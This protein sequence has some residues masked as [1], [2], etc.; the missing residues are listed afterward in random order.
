MQ[1]QKQ[2]AID[3]ARIRYLEEASLVQELEDMLQEVQH[4][5]L[6]DT[7]ACDAA[8]SQ[9]D[10]KLQQAGLPCPADAALS[11]AKHMQAAYAA[12]RLQLPAVPQQQPLHGNKSSSVAGNVSP[13]DVDDDPDQLGSMHHLLGVTPQ[14]L[15]TLYMPNKKAAQKAHAPVMPLLEQRVEQQAQEAV[16]AVAGAAAGPDAAAH[17]LSSIGEKQGQLS[18][19]R[20]ACSEK[21]LSYTQCAQGHLAEVAAMQQRLVQLGQCILSEQPA[22]DQKHREYLEAHMT[23]LLGKLATMQ[24]QMRDGTYDARTVPALQAIKQQL[25]RT[26]QEVT[27]AVEQVNAQLLGYS[28]LGDEFS[29]IVQEFAVVKSKT[30]DLDRVLEHL[31]KVEKEAAYF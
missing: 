29:G 19:L 14:Q 18:A 6:D 22:L 10:A 1:Q 13:A 4:V 7:T 5:L 11:L 24:L 23:Q 26:E 25:Q 30:E 17:V 12:Q 27:A 20:A 2:Q 8:S 16:A 31:N 15:R 28:Q 9:A 21:L 3:Q